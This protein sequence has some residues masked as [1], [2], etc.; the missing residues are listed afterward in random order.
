MKGEFTGKHM[1]AVLVTGFGIVVAVNFT[2]AAFAVKGFNGVVVENSYVASQNYNGWLD[3]ARAQEALGWSATMAR[4]PDGR[5]A[6]A[7]GGVP[8]SAKVDAMLRRPMGDSTV[9]HLALRPRGDGAYAS[10]DPLP[11][12]RWIVRLTVSAHGDEWKGEG[13]VD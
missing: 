12:G 2:M 1:L 8:A 13:E 10:A 4:A 6:I 9:T 3:R 11:G 5:L 7:T